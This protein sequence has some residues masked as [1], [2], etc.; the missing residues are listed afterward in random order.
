M[1]TIIN[2]SHY[3]SV[4]TDIIIM[5]QE[6]FIAGMAVSTLYIFIALCI[7]TIVRGPLTPLELTRKAYE[8]QKEW[9]DIWK[10][11]IDRGEIEKTTH[12]NQAGDPVDMYRFNGELIQ[13]MQLSDAFK[14]LQNWNLIEESVNKQKFFELNIAG[15][16]YI[17]RL[18]R[19]RN[20]QIMVYDEKGAAPKYDDIFKYFKSQEAAGV[21]T[22]DE[23]AKQILN[24]AREEIGKQSSFTFASAE[25]LKKGMRDLMIVGQVAEAASMT[26]EY[27]NHLEENFHEAEIFKAE[28]RNSFWKSESE[29]K[30]NNENRK[31]Y[32]TDADYEDLYQ[33]S[34]E[35]RIAS[36]EKE[37]E[38][39]DKIAKALPEPSEAFFEGLENAEG[40]TDRR[41]ATEEVVEKLGVEKLT[42]EQYNNI[43]EATDILLTSSDETEKAN[44]KKTILD[45]IPEL[46]DTYYN[47]LT[48]LSDTC[49][50]E[51]DESARNRWNSFVGKRFV[52]DGKSISKVG[53]IPGQDHI[54]RD[55]IRTIAETPGTSS[56]KPKFTE[57]FPIHLQGGTL[58]ARKRLYGDSYTLDEDLKE[59]EESQKRFKKD[60]KAAAD[61]KGTA[62]T[63]SDAIDDALGASGC[64]MTYSDLARSSICERKD[65]KI[66]ED[67]FQ[68]EGDILSFET[69][70]EDGI[71]VKN[72]VAIDMEDMGLPK[73]VDENIANM[74]ELGVK[75]EDL[76][77]HP[78]PGSGTEAASKALGIYGSFVGILSSAKYLQMGEYGEATF[79]ILQTVYTIGG[80]SGFN[81]VVEEASEMAFAKLMGFTADKAGVEKAMERMM[82]MAAEAVGETASRVLD[83]VVGSLPFIGLAFDLYFVAEDIK[84]LQ[85][86]SSD[87]PF[88]LK[89]AHLVLDVSITELTLV[90]S[91]IP[92]AAPFTEPLIIA[93]TII[94]VSIDDFYMDIKR[95]LSKA[96]G[97]SFA[98]QVEAFVKGFAEG[99][100]DVLTLGLFTQLQSL[101]AQVD[102]DDELLKNMSDPAKY[103]DYRFNN[104]QGD[105]DFTSGAVSQY[106]GFLD[107][108][109]H[110][111]GSVRM[112]MAE[113]PDENGLP[114]TIVET[115]DFFSPI[116]EIIL[117][118]G[119]TQTPIYMQETAYLWMFIPIKSDDVI[120]DLDKHGSSRY[121]VYTGNDMNNT[122]YAL[123]TQ[124]D[125][126]AVK[127]DTTDIPAIQVEQSTSNPQ[128]SN[129]RFMRN[130]QDVPMKRSTRDSGNAFSRVHTSQR[131]PSRQHSTQILETWQPSI[132]SSQQ[133]HSTSNKQLMRNIQKRDFQKIKIDASQPLKKSAKYAFANSEDE[134]DD[135]NAATNISMY[136][137]SYNY[138]LYGKDGDD[139][140]FLGPQQTFISGD[141]GKDLYYIQPSGGKTI[142]DNFAIDDETDTLYFNVTYEN[143]KC[144]RDEWDLVIGFCDTHLVRLKNWFNHE[145]Y[146]FYQHIYIV[147]K[148]GI[149]MEATESDIN[150]GGYSISCDAVIVDKTGGIKNQLI[151]MTVGRFKHVQ[152]AYGSN[153]SDLIEGNELGNLIS[154]GNGNDR[155]I[156]NGG[157]DI[158]VIDRASGNDSINNY[159]EDFEEDTIIFSVLYTNIFVI[160][161]YDNLIMYD[162]TEPYHLLR[163][164]QWF[165][166]SLYQHA[167]FLSKDY[168]QFTVEL[169]STGVPLLIALTIDL[170]EYK[171][172]VLID[173][174]DTRHNVN[175]TVNKEEMNDVK[176][177]F[178]SPYNDTLIGNALGNFFTCTGGSDYLKGNSGKETYIADINCHHLLIDNHDIVKDMDLLLIR[179]LFKN[180]SL[181]NPP[182]SVHLSIICTRE[183]GQQ[184]EVTLLHWF[185]GL[186]F[187]HLYIKT[188]DL[189]TSFPPSNR[190]E[191]DQSKGKLTPIELQ[192]NEGCEGHVLEINLRFPEYSKV[193]RVEVSNS[194]CSH[195]IYGNNINNYM[196]P[197]PGNPF[198]YQ[199]MEGGNG[200]D[201]YVLG[202]NYGTYNMIN[203]FAEDN[204]T[205]HLKF[206]VIFDDIV[207]Q[208]EEYNINISSKSQ[209]DSVQAII[210]NY[211]VGSLYQHLVVETADNFM[212]RFIAKYP[213]I[214]VIMVDLSS[215]KFSQ[216]I[217][218]HENT[219]FKDAIILIGSKTAK[220][221]I[222]GGLYS[223][224]IIGGNQSDVIY[225]GP[226]DEDL[227]GFKGVDLIHGG[228]GNDGI[229]GGEDDDILFGDE[230]DDSFFGGVGADMIYG[231]NGS[232][233][234]VFS[235]VDYSGV[236]ANLQVNIGMYNDAEN[237][238]YDSIESILASEFDDLLIGNN[239]NNILRSYAGHDTI[240]TYGGFDLLH[241]G[242]GSDL[243][244]LDEAS[245]PK[246]IN[247][248]ATDEAL[249]MVSLKNYSSEA[250]CY[251]YLEED[252]VMNIPFDQNNQDTI[253]RVIT[254]EDFLE[255][256][257]T[258]ALSNTTYQHLLFF[259]SD[260]QLYIEEFIVNGNQIG[261]IYNQVYSGYFLHITCHT[262]TTICIHVNY[263]KI[264]ASD[265][266]P[267]DK[268]MLD[269]IQVT[270]NASIHYPLSYIYNGGDETIQ[271][272]N[273]QSGVENTFFG[274][275][276]SCGL[277]VTFS[278]LLTVVTIPNQPVKLEVDVVVFDGFQI[279]WNSPSNYT[280]PLVGNYSYVIK[281]ILEV[282][283][284]YLQFETNDTEFTTTSLL[285]QTEYKVLVYSKSLNTSSRD[286]VGLHL[287]TDNHTCSNLNDLPETMYIHNFDRNEEDL[288]IANLSCIQGYR[289]IGNPYAVCDDLNVVLPTCESLAC[290]IPIV[291]NATLLTNNFDNG[292]NKPLEGDM[293]IWECNKNFEVSVNI[294]KF[295]STCKSHT[296]APL[297]AKCNLLPQ[298]QNLS[299]PKN[300]SI[301]ET[302]VFI[303]ENVTYHCNHGYALV[304]PMMKYCTRTYNGSLDLIPHESNKCEH[305]HCPSLI[306]QVDGSYSRSPPYYEDDVVILSCYFGY[307]ISNRYENPQMAEYQCINSQ[308]NITVE[309]CM[310]MIAT[311]QVVEKILVIQA[312]FTWSFSAWNGVTMTGD[313][314]HHGCLQLGGTKYDTTL[315]GGHIQCER[316]IYLAN[317][318]TSFEG[319]LAVSDREEVGGESYVCI[320]STIVAEEICDSLGYHNY[321]ASIYYSNAITTSKTLIGNS[322][323]GNLTNYVTS[324]TT[325]ISCKARCD[326]LELLNGEGTCPHGEPYEGDTCTF[327]CNNGYYLVGDKERQCTSNGWTG[328]H[329]FCDGKLIG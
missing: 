286:A 94:R 14:L 54:F 66:M 251:F 38:L 293:L 207:V 78:P 322:I 130:V 72:K 55:T 213:Y 321:K 258:L 192:F 43:K 241:G 116:D 138:N 50:I 243:Y 142:I 214:E 221:H 114:Q 145:R 250:V 299:P 272:N 23:I 150:G 317:G 179:C 189:V 13:R 125:S 12:P 240:F 255:V 276:S 323:H 110:N 139:K 227:V 107:V 216:V 124:A 89:I 236:S 219:S 40:E 36:P 220:N 287:V 81:R 134:C 109:L 87:T 264:N 35:L 60:I 191:Y 49:A 194:S 27:F 155:L 204:Q 120:A 225:G 123:Q 171:H 167:N 324:C 261:P 105:L 79:S 186:E 85:D 239:D 30:F 319:I 17:F 7:I 51:A 253:G 296:W 146:E 16:D 326:P 217:S 302:K 270:N 15:E 52:K 199:H 305:T 157:K 172:G 273:L 6:F 269:L 196:D 115:F 74:E 310:T 289:L 156:G 45:N 162:K 63:I 318:P 230:G 306:P 262:E 32:D 210:V 42:D 238:T 203:N 237:D 164:E 283:N 180:L 57:A 197:G 112:V 20:N 320:D 93:L 83:R 113:V 39:K 111:N 121:G 290:Y 246:V 31:I 295:N 233:F 73:Y 21:T 84:D 248:F 58:K 249:D 103:F 294:T 278:P 118:V 325:R 99:I 314:Y 102:F 181:F 316:A 168:V 69:I 268:Y 282:T 202:H 128:V 2:M 232:D 175:Y 313:Y 95:E 76:D 206:D 260:V 77:P 231:G 144:S 245:G 137:K 29:E 215:S 108:K 127:R 267:A 208:R 271:L 300:G 165:T 187:Q 129:K 91:L 96:N 104:S 177:I 37:K 329:T 309:L 117:G 244:M 178:D 62:D 308:W 185:A 149:I 218:P 256:T 75:R 301:S 257:V 46:T 247:N 235:G 198:G 19:D 135:P 254:A 252:L 152:D 229:Y 183:A 263:T 148:D 188:D 141:N 265:A 3:Y 158:Y 205:D 97:K 226:G 22:Q 25:K 61:G 28:T 174:N 18:K 288:L 277:S 223:H 291:A 92:E 173:L 154:P 292:T 11:L 159:A 53:R 59:A 328:V 281:I 169:N 140:F 327:Q 297:P 184:F 209:N 170:S 100:V 65:M 106:G 82:E 234:I 64:S 312:K 311:S 182:N 151:N 86:K 10:E 275:L 304:G 315:P 211:F 88:G 34:E 33:L 201:V 1:H 143:I 160:R 132:S 80:M 212:F 136:L 98:V 67:T 193:E 307:Y 41:K 259:F 126:Q 163:I 190:T 48:E 224:Q 133:V 9:R 195:S 200:T 274:Y 176:V 280:D 119:E 242:I 266:P 161:K 153:Y 44:A 24:S 4:C 5:I 90:E 222:T 131:M 284:E 285:P 298:C 26:D 8:A 166:S 71:R 122:F 68:W 279:H 228:N 303:G 56:F 101:Q 47:D 70:D 147:S